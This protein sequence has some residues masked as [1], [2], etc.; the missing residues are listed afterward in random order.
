MGHRSYHKLIGVADGK[1]PSFPLANGVNHTTKP[2]R[3]VTCAPSATLSN[4]NDTH[5]YLIFC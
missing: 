1:L 5:S 2:R 3:G 4:A